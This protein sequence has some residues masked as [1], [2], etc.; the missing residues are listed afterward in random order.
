MDTEEREKWLK[1][2]NIGICVP[3]KDKVA[4]EKDIYMANASE[5]LVNLQEEMAPNF[6]NF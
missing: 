3:L 5:R 2:S 6:N 1:W 4:N